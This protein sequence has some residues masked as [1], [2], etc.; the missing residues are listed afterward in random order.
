MAKRIS[1]WIM[2]LFYVAA[3]IRHFTHT[4]FYMQMMPPFVPAHLTMV[5]VSGV[6][7]AAL[8]L[9]LLIPRLSR[10]AAWV[11]VALLIC[12]FPANLYMWIAD[13]HIDGRA[14]PPVF[15]AI[16]L[17]FQAVFIAWAYWHTRGGDQRATAQLEH[18]PPPRAT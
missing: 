17:P 14:V 16:R 9:A 8:G 6:A 1:L 11:L 13:V 2:A 15:H 10:H 12:V 7:E 4:S 3:G 18:A 5:Y